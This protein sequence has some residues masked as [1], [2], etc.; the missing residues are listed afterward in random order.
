M[1]FALSLPR[2]VAESQD[3][4]ET[5][6]RGQDS[7]AFWRPVI[8]CRHNHIIYDSSRPGMRPSINPGHSAGHTR[9]DFPRQTLYLY[10]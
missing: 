10:A 2:E 3:V 6:D 5:H 7:R 4:G 8:D 9:V 1:T